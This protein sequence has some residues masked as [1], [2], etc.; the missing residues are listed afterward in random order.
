MSS[1]TYV[2]PLSPTYGTHVIGHVTTE[3]TDYPLGPVTDVDVPGA[4]V[5]LLPFGLT[6]TTD[7]GGVFAFC[8]LAV[9]ASP[10]LV[11]VSVQA[12]GYSPWTI[13]NVQVFKNDAAE[14]DVRLQQSGPATVI[15]DSIYWSQRQTTSNATTPATTSPAALA[16]ASGFSFSKVPPAT[17][18]V[19]I[20][21]WSNGR[22][23]GYMKITTPWFR[24]ASWSAGHQAMVL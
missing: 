4:T 17:I 10:Q 12:P 8:N 18:R 15:D 11:S 7:A 23:V 20:A 6:T 21:Q 16:A 22:V 9:A 24:P 1:A 14:L 19:A 13:T 2:A 3:G 5:R